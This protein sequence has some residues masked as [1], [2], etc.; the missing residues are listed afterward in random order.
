MGRLCGERGTAQAFRAAFRRKKRDMPH[1]PAHPRKAPRSLPS[2]PLIYPRIYICSCRSFAS[3]APA[4]R[5]APYRPAC[6]Y[7]LGYTPVPAKGRMPRRAPRSLPP[8]LPIYPRIYACSRQRSNAP[9]AARPFPPPRA[10]SSR[11]R[12]P[13]P[14][15]AGASPAPAARAMGANHPRPRTAPAFRAP[16]RRKKRDMPH[17]PA[18]QPGAI[19][20]APA[21]GRLGG[22]RRPLQVKSESGDMRGGFGSLASARPPYAGRRLRR[23][24]ACAQWALGPKAQS[25]PKA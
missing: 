17:S 10:R 5:P 13:I 2:R 25:D 20:P 22:A 18:H 14:A 8:R 12:A 7:I 23:R 9:A 19:R 1:R 4:K 16:F 6:Q 15:A 11:R 24:E 21:V 3:N